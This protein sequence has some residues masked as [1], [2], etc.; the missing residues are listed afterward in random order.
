LVDLVTFVEIK[1]KQAK[2]NL[3]NC[4]APQKLFICYEVY[5]EQEQRSR[6]LLYLFPLNENYNLVI[7]FILLYIL[8]MYVRCFSNSTWF[9]GIYIH[10]LYSLIMHSVSLFTCPGNKKESKFF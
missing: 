9:R 6:F 1:N 2:N 7:F 4:T 10:S 3:S 5:F 8:A